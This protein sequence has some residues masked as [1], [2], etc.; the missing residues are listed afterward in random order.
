MDSQQLLI[1]QEKQA[2][3]LADGRTQL[4]CFADEGLLALS[5]ALEQQFNQELLQQAERLLIK[6]IRHER[7]NVVPYLGVAQLRMLSAEHRSALKYLRLAQ[8]F[9]P[10]HAQVQEL[11]WHLLLYEPSAPGK[12]AGI[13]R[14]HRGYDADDVAECYKHELMELMRDLSL[15]PCPQ[16]PL[17]QAVELEEFQTL[18]S[19][20]QARYAELI[21]QL[22]QLEAEI[23]TA[24]LR[25]RTRPLEQVLAKHAAMLTLSQAYQDF[26]AE[27]LTGRDRVE[28]LLIQWRQAQASRSSAEWDHELE[29]LLDLCD[30]YADRLDGFAAQG[31]SIQLIKQSY[32]QLTAWVETFRDQLDDLN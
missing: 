22:D 5:Q 31:H 7:A 23:E 20:F 15:H 11:I 28:Q 25:R 32:K 1:L 4:H 14:K 12:E 3:W 8:T 2:Q 17:V 24:G 26:Q 13:G 21:T 29:V 6:A 16:E 9:A 19:L 27:L 10:G 18:Y 30:T